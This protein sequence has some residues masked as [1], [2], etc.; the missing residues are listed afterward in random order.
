MTSTNSDNCGLCVC[1]GA[2]E[3]VTEELT[4]L[5]EQLQEVNNVADSVITRTVR[6]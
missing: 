6:N 5:K 1:I 4:K 2:G 3:H